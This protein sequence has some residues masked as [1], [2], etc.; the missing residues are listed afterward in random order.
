[1]SGRFHFEDQFRTV[2]IKENEK[3]IE[4][5]FLDDTGVRWALR[6]REELR[7]LK[8]H[9]IGNVRFLQERVRYFMKKSPLTGAKREMTAKARGV[10]KEILQ[11]AAEDSHTEKEKS[12]G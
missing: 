1:M 11:L 5:V 4:I 8:E 9:E 10:L 2:V 6:P 7:Y 12:N 3:T